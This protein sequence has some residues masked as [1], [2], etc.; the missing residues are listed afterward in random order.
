M[1]RREFMALLGAAASWPL[2]ARAQQESRVR[3]V[4]L[5]LSAA[6]T[7]VEYQGYL[8][9]FLHEMRQLGW[10]EGQNLQIEVRWNTGDAVL[11][12]TYAEQLIALMPDVIV[13]GSTVNLAAV[14]HAT[15]TI[16]IVFVQVA[17]PVTQGF[18]S[19]MQQPGG[20]I[21][22]FSLYEFSL[23]GK[24][25]NLLKE[26]APSLKRVAVMFNPGTAP[27]IKFFLPVFDA[28]VP[29]LGLQLVTL[30]VLT[31]SD[32]ERAVMQ[33]VREPNGGLMLLG[34][35]FPRLHIK[36][37]AELAGRYRLPSIAPINLANLG[38]LM[39]YG[40]SSDL[41][42]HFRQA[43]IYVDRILKGAAPGALPI[44]SPTKYKLVVNLK[45]AKSLGLTV[46]ASLLAA[47]DEVIE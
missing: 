8:A 32:I 16:P 22:G 40:P 18:V 30:P 12:Q 35:S 21:T 11:S 10:S 14:Q 5:L 36:V 24:W 39:D 44:Q 2:A 25:L 7:E 13:T 42:H 37:I 15:N 34:D 33:F 47:A 4:G 1:K 29:S 31:E 3:R 26:I 20:N 38:G 41:A 46:P 23:G 28:T 27:Y 45:T 9:A 6:A 19:N 43:A 17:D